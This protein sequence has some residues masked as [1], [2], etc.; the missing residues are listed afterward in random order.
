M[1][2][3]YHAEAQPQQES[4]DIFVGTVHSQP[5]VAEPTSERIILTLVSF[6]PGGRTKWHR[7][8]FEQGLVIVEGKGIVATEEAEHVVTPGD[9]VYVPANEKHW[10]GG[11][12]TTAMAH[13]AINQPGETTVL[14]P[15][16]VR[17]QV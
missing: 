16:E 4:R 15:S 14:E 13:I 2:V 10:H 1:K 5:L 12:M 11:S 3:H 7:H 6:S 9:V 8:S 17:T